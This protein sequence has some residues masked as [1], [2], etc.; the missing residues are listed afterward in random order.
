MV[1]LDHDKDRYVWISELFWETVE[2]TI[3]RMNVHVGEDGIV[4]RVAFG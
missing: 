2:I 3:G 4:K 1:T